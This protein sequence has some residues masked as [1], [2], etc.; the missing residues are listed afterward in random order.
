M[1]KNIILSVIS[2]LLLV[3]SFSPVG[4]G[5]L[6]WAGL[7]P[8]LFALQGV[9]AARPGEGAR[10]SF[11]LGWLW[12]FVFS[13]GTVYWVVNSMYYYG[14]IPLVPGALIMLVLAAYLALFPAVFALLFYLTSGNRPLF[15]LFV[16]PAL[17][18]SLEFIKGLLFTG[19]PWALLGYSQVGFTTLIQVADIS[20][21]WGV[22]Y[23]V[24]LLNSGIFLFILNLALG[25]G[26]RGLRRE[27]FLIFVATAAVFVVVAVYG[28]AQTA[29]VGKELASWPQVKVAAVQGNIGQA[30]KW[31][32]SEQKKIIATYRALI[33]RASASFASLNDV[34]DAGAGSKEP[35]L[36]VLPETSMPFFLARD[37]EM[38]LLVEDMARDSGSYLLIGAPDYKPDGGGGYSILNAAFMFSPAG[39]ITGRYDKM[40]LVPFGEYVPLKRILFFIEKLTAGAGEFVEGR[41]LYPVGLELGGV[42]TSVGTFICYEAIFPSLVAELARGGPEPEGNDGPVAGAGLLVNITNDAWFGDTSAPHH[43][44]DMTIMRAVENRS[45]LVRSANTGIS[46]IVSPT[47]EVVE[48]TGLFEAAVITATVGLRQGGPTFFGRHPDL[49]PC[50]LL[51]FSAIIVVLG[52]RFRRRTG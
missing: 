35:G 30:V 14:G 10:R 8:F 45:F 50:V 21:V 29:S 3:A 4:T 34:D 9:C 47:G 1:K 48:S 39:A 16:I 15:R 37:P 41:G 17:W 23:W 6:A 5:A 11:F 22:S 7:V 12:G 31:E 18:V 25:S 51:I 33:S 28:L 2:A 52:L 32:A 40:H 20:G 36:I 27:P 19:F 44:L 49:F 42:R 13:V 26:R 43:H 38:L 24:M 46:A